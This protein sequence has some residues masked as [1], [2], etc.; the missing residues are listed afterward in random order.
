MHG[1]LWFFGVSPVPSGTA[2]TY[3]LWS[4]FIPALTV[5]G[6]STLIIGAWHHLDCH[7]N[8][9]LRLA[10]APVEGTPWKTCWR[11]HPTGKPTHAHIL[12]AHRQ[13]IA[14]RQ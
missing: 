10:R 11:H 4:G 7:T 13:H 5:L 1:I 3:Q 12:E 14:K 2:A 8:G 9:C 6:L